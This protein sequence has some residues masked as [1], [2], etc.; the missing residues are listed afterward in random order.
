[1]TAAV[2]A[3]RA[4]PHPA[5]LLMLIRTWHVYLGMIIAPATLFM[6][7]TGILQVYNLHEDGPGYKP[8]AVLERLG[9]LHKK[10]SLALKRRQRPEAATAAAG[11]GRGA[12]A[13]AGPRDGEPAASARSGPPPEAAPTKRGPSRP[14]VAALKAF[15]ALAAGGLIASTAAGLWMALRSPKRRLIHLALLAAGAVIPAVLAAL[16]L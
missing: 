3:S 15:F 11:P 6:A 5:A 8:P 13:E 12:P 10:Q 4:K 16:T 2:A 7:I 9:A 14:A 1:M